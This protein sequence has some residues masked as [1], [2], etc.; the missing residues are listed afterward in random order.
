MC[1]GPELEVAGLSAPR[2]VGVGDA[3]A[4]H[5]VGD[6]QNPQDVAVG[7]DVDVGVGAPGVGGQDPVVQ[8]LL[9]VQGD[10][11][12]PQVR[13]NYPEGKLKPQP[14]KP[15]NGDSIMVLRVPGQSV[16]CPDEAEPEGG[17]EHAIGV[18][19]HPL[20]GEAQLYG[21]GGGAP[22]GLQGGAWQARASP[23]GSH[24]CHSQRRWPPGGRRGGCRRP[25]GG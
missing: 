14:A 9:V 22:G 8:V 20:G 25:W 5:L 11:G 23:G 17:G 3:L 24:A 6:W 21:Q 4:E 16:V 18:Q 12:L 1:P 2:P 13:R 19:V 7:V 15:E 10:V